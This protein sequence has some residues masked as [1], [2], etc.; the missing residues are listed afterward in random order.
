M[1]DVAKEKLAVINMALGVG[2]AALQ[3]FP[4]TASQYSSRRRSP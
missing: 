2:F 3:R 4:Q 1:Q